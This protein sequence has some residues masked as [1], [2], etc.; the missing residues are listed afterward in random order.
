MFVCV[1]DD[2]AVG[3][4]VG[5]VVVAAVVAAAVADGGDAVGGGV[6]VV[7]EVRLEMVQTCLTRL[8]STPFA[9]A[10][11]AMAARAAAPPVGTVGSHC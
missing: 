2:V 10:N 7:V 9:R 1:A 3:V 8:D 5:A 6:E 11:I 4:V